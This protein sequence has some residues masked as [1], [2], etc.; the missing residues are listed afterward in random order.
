MRA[1]VQALGLAAVLF[2]MAGCGKAPGD[3]T[4]DDMTLGS[5]NAPVTLIEYA[6]VT[7]THCATFNRDILPELKAKYIDAGKVRYVY[8]E[9]LTPPENV[10]AAG[11][12]LARCAGRDKY[13]QMVDSIM[14]A[15]P[16]MFADD[17]TEGALPVL[18]QIGQSA[19]LSPAEIDHCM[20]DP[21]G[22]ARI[23]A[24]MAA[25]DKA[26][27]IGDNGTPAFYINGKKVERVKGDV[28]DFDAALTPLLAEN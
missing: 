5:A 8:R 22:L 4:A 19:G 16:Q 25:Y 12:L 24:N 15:Q 7:C 21:K 20:T 23:Q 17:T 14:R 28:S 13:F 18:R 10:S 6:S 26:Y 9:Y 11:A 2:M 27:H 3:V 1:G